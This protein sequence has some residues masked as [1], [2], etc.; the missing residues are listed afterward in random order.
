MNKLNPFLSKSFKS[1]WLKHF[2]T[3]NSKIEAFNYFSGLEFVKH[4]NRAVYFN[5]GETY[6]KGIDY[7]IQSANDSDLK[8]KAFLICAST[9]ASSF[10]D[11][12]SSNSSPKQKIAHIS[13]ANAVST[14]LANNA[15]VSLK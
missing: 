8:N 15:S 9:M 6:T 11:L 1:I 7:E 2:N 3:K 4:A 5:V 12:R 10:P 13:C 14:F